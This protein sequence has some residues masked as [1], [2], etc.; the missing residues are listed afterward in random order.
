MEFRRS[1]RVNNGSNSR[2]VCAILPDFEAMTCSRCDFLL[3][4]SRRPVTDEHFAGCVSG[5]LR[6]QY[7]ICIPT[8][9]ND[10]DAALDGT[11]IYT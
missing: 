5:S 3:H 4:L 9:A 11:F 7:P 8:A 1:K 2:P 6:F 10:V